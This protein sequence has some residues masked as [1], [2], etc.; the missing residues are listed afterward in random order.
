MPEIRKSLLESGSLE[1]PELI[2]L[3]VH[4]TDVLCLDLS[5]DHASYRSFSKRVQRLIK[6]WREFFPFCPNLFCIYRYSLMIYPRK[7]EEEAERKWKEKERKRTP[8]AYS[9]KLVI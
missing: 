5:G 9:F 1:S 4:S 3:L 8:L 6:K 2:S 7:K